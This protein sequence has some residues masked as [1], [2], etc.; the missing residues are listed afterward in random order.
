[1]SST[2]NPSQDPPPIVLRAR[3]I[4][5]KEREQ[6]A[7]VSTF[8][9]FIPAFWSVVDPAP[10]KS[11]WVTDALADHL[12]A[13]YEREIRRLKVNIHFRSAKST[14]ASILW[15]AWIWAK[16]PAE[17]FLFMSYAEKLA[18]THAGHFRKCIKSDKYRLMFGNQFVLTKDSDGEIENT[19]L[20]ARLS[21][22]SASQQTGSGGG[23]KVFDDPNDT[24]KVEYAVDRD[25]VNNRFDNMSTRSDDFATDVWVLI[26]QRT[27]P[28]DVSGHIDELG[29]LGFETLNIPLEY[30]GKKYVTSLGWSDPRTKIGEVTDEDRFPH[31]TAAARG[32]DDAIPPLKAS[33]G[34]RYSGQA[35]QDPTTAEGVIV[36]RE[37]FQRESNIEYTGDANEERLCIY[38]DLGGSASPNADFTV[39]SALFRQGGDGRDRNSRYLI[40]WQL[41]GQWDGY[42]RDNEM[43]K[44]CVTWDVIFP[45]IPIRIES[46]FGL[47]KDVAPDILNRL[48]DSGLNV[49]LDWARKRKF[50]RCEPV[51]SAAKAGRI[52]CYD[53]T[54]FAKHGF[55]NGEKE[56][57][58]P[59]LEE[60]ARLKVRESAQG[61]EF[62]DAHDDR[63]DSL[64]G[65]LDTITH[66][67][68]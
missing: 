66:L 61:P 11:S 15:P 38:W 19:K 65:A 29:G 62:Y 10:F 47:A 27:H 21:I 54:A 6:D 63:L 64:A 56:W 3:D 8:R 52:Y 51:I 49:Q 39:G 67:A 43:E 25:N 2:L 32:L 37:W 60:F 26:Q 9:D 40:L 5:N 7:I 34:F 42:D 13:C 45:S 14:L 36:K 33:L 20:G 35:N 23:I 50:A 53:G 46:T 24:N 68:V 4:R 18:L 57:I 17:K 48:I 41:A 59:M 22:G 44:F 12:Q 55:S 30:S 28:K 16:T 1:M 31:W 58:I